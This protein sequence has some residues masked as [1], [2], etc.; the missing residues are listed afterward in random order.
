MNI[1]DDQRAAFI[2]D[3]GGAPELS[4]YTHPE[5]MF[6]WLGIVGLRTEATLL[7]RLQGWARANGIPQTLA[8]TLVGAA[9]SPLLDEDGVQITDEDNVPITL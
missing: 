8:L 6:L 7:E 1:L 5:L 4:R 3:L 9:S 2:L